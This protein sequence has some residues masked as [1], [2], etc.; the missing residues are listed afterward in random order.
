MCVTRARGPG[1]SGQPIWKGAAQ[2]LPQDVCGALAGWLDREL[3]LPPSDPCSVLSGPLHQQGQPPWAGRLPRAWS[4][5][6][7]II[8]VTS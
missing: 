3:P 4:C 1:Q 8:S 6:D 2:E 5:M 7:L